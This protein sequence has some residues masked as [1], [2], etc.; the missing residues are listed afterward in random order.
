MKT[1]ERLQ[2]ALLTLRLGVFIV[3]FVWTLDKLLRP[4]H[5]AS[6]FERYYGISGMGAFASYFLGALELLLILAFVVGVFKRYTYG[7]VLVL[8]AISTLASFGKYVAPFEGN[9]LLFFAAWPM[10]AACFTLY[11]L[12]DAD[13]LWT[14]GGRD[15]QRAGVQ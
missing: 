2:L 15:G 1:E 10:L 3:F 4:E 12:R 14:F 8:H 6:V 13:T 5:T 9:N 7:A 11:T